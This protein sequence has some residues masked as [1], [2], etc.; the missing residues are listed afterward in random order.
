MKTFQSTP[1]RRGRRQ[2]LQNIPTSNPRFNPRPR[3]GGD[4]SSIYHV[5]L[6]RRFNPRPREGGDLNMFTSSRIFTVVSIHAPAKGATAVLLCSWFLGTAFQSTP[7]RRG[8]LML[9][10][11]ACNCSLFQST[12]PRRGRPGT[13]YRFQVAAPFQS[14]PPRRGRLLAAVDV[15]IIRIVSIHAPAKGATQNNSLLNCDNMGFNPRPREG[16]DM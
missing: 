8:R 6:S 3:E 1:P 11:S 15:R 2:T 14:T 10:K 16:G 9:V 5:L 7:P 4:N 13:V 12:P